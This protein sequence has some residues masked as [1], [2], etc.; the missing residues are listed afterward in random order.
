MRNG[1]RWW[2]QY[3]SLVATRTAIADEV[4]EGGYRRWA[5]GIERHSVMC[6]RNLSHGQRQQKGNGQV[7]LRKIRSSINA[8]QAD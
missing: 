7:G 1:I 4:H 5:T 2:I 8:V 3:A 6:Q